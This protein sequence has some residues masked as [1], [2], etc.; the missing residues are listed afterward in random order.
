MVFEHTMDRVLAG[1]LGKRAMVYIDDIVIYSRRKA[2]YL[3]HLQFFFHRL[4]DANKMF[5]WTAIFQIT[6]LY[7]DR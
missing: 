5:L 6:R 7:C 3:L 4:R 1:L 2:E